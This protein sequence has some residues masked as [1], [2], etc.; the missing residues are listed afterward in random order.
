MIMKGFAYLVVWKLMEKPPILN[1]LNSLQDHIAIPTTRSRCHNILI[2]WERYEY[3][4]NQEIHN[5]AHGSHSLRYFLLMYFA[6]ILPLKSR[7]HKC[8]SQP[9]YHGIGTGEC[10]PA[11]GER[12]NERRSVTLE[13]VRDYGE[14]GKR[15]GEE[16]QSLCGGQSRCRRSGHCCANNHYLIEK[17]KLLRILRVFPSIGLLLGLG[18]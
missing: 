3:R 4:H 13:G 6:H 15:E 11:K 9:S 5:S 18:E 8:R 2:K 12:C 14:T 16:T 7:L 1:V 17:G 10:E